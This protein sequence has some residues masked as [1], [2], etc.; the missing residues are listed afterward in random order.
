MTEKARSVI[1]GR[2]AATDISSIFLYLAMEAS[3][4]VADG[5]LQS[6]AT[7]YKY[8][9]RFPESEVELSECSPDI[10]KMRRWPVPRFANYLVY[11][12]MYEGNVDI[13]R[14]LHGARDVRVLLENF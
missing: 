7:A 6:L 10:Q 9:Q 11:Y 2:A 8:P 12:R 13:V 5:F 1:L 3:L 14:I 4:E